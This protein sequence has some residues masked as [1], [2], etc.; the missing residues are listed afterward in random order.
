MYEKAVVP[1][2][3]ELC[4]GENYRRD[5]QAFLELLRLVKLVSR[6]NSL[7]NENVEA[8]VRLHTFLLE[9]TTELLIS[10]TYSIAYY[11]GRGSHANS[12][13]GPRRTDRNRSRRHLYRQRAA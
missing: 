11:I 4:R 9:R 13:K 1:L 5:V 2:I 12:Q 10:V 8:K 6:E 7:A 3:V